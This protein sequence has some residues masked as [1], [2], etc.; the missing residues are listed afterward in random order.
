MNFQNSFY[1]LVQIIDVKPVAF[2]LRALTIILENF[3]S[4]ITAN[5]M[6]IPL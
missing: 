5:I 1:Y 3:A 6:N 4:L 2:M